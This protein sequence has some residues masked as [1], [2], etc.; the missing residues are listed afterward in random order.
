MTSEDISM[1]ND[2]ITPYDFG[3]SINPQGGFTKQYTILYYDSGHRIVLK[4][5]QSTEDNPNTSNG[6]QCLPLNNMTTYNYTDNIPLNPINCQECNNADYSDIT[7]VAKWASL[8]QPVFFLAYQ[9]WRAFKVKPKATNDYQ[10]LLLNQYSN[11]E[12]VIRQNLESKKND[13]MRSNIKL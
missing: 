2:Y 5:Y 10:S 8:V 3:G 9:T 7:F 1:T 11:L 12:N 13:N 4:N 6:W